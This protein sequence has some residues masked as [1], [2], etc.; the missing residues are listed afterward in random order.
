[1]MVVAGWGEIERIEKNDER[2]WWFHAGVKG[3]MRS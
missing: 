2:A 3:E 1:M